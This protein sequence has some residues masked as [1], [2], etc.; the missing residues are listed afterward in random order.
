MADGEA[1]SHCQN[2]HVCSDVIASSNQMPRT[3]WNRLNIFRMKAHQDAL[4]IEQGWQGKFIEA[5]GRE[6]VGI[7]HVFSDNVELGYGWCTVP[8]IG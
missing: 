7:L 5:G 1:H 4:G 3:D 8:M 2:S 6:V